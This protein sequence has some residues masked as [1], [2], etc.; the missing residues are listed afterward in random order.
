[1]IS[2]QLINSKKKKQKKINVCLFVSFSSSSPDLS[3]SAVF[4]A[5]IIL[6]RVSLSLLA[7]YI[8]FVTLLFKI[9]LNF[10]ISIFFSFDCLTTFPLRNLFL[11]VQAF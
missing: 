1:M 8:F 10:R 3:S 5:T 11:L 2:V 7:L 4:G 6:V 9:L